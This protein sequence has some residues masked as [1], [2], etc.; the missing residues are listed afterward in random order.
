MTKMDLYKE[1][2]AYFVKIGTPQKLVYVVD[3]AVATIKILQS[4]TSDIRINDQ[5]MK[6]K[7][8]C[9][10]LILDRK[11]EIL[12]ISD[13]NSLIF[14]IKLAEWQRQCSSAGYIPVIRVSYKID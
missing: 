2:T 8:I 7:K 12:R 11:R 5:I 10:W 4:Q 9:L 1:N 3:Q 13:I 14:L 6:L